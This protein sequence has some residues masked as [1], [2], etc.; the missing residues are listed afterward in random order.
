MKTFATFNSCLRSK[1]MFASRTFPISPQGSICLDLSKVK[2]CSL[3]IYPSKS[4][5][6]S[7]DCPDYTMES[8]KINEKAVIDSLP[9]LIECDFAVCKREPFENIVI[10]IPE[11]CNLSVDSQHLDLL[12]DTKFH[13]NFSVTST[14]GLIDINKIRGAKIVVNAPF[15]N[16][17]VKKIE[18]N[19]SIAAGNFTAK[20]LYGDNMNVSSDGDLSIGAMYTKTSYLHS[21]RNLT[22][23]HMQGYAQVNRIFFEL[24]S[25]SCVFHAY[26]T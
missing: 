26:I 15:S 17:K 19:A 4:S 20:M 5:H 18:G 10:E 11:L 13:G 14:S 22:V 8:T 6:L 9:S 7:I 24:L 16:F 2:N 3:K 12:I 21:V 1:R 23:G 25:H